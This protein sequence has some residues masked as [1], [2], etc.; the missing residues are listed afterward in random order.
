MV[1]EGLAA[2][3]RHASVFA[4]PTA[5]K[6]VAFQ[7]RPT[8]NGASVHTSGPSTAPPVWLRLL[9][10]GDRI[11]AYYRLSSTGGWTSIGSQT[12]AGLAG[13]VQVGLAVSSHVD[14][15]RA[16]ATFD[17]VTIAE[18]DPYSIADVG[19]VGMRGTWSLGENGLSIEGSGADIWGTADAFRYYYRLWS[20]NGTITVR[21]DGVEN[22]H[23]WAKAGVMFRETLAAGSK[24]V[25]AIV[26]PGKGV[27]VQYR[28]A[29]GGTS[30]NA[31]L[32]P[33]TAP[34]WLR[35]TRSGNTFTAFASED[36]SSWRTLGTTTVTM[37]AD[38][39]VGLPVT[40]HDN[41]MLATALFNG[42]PAVD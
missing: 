6:G 37:G 41:A 40:S 38:I 11:G 28:G 42:R 12:L 20:G 8:T 3:S 5:V 9:R 19:A 18:V 13:V 23:A 27:A 32:A 33:G 4:T 30:A 17:N 31:A 15:R 39:L 25:M 26:S 16:M 2:G 10:T 29:T 35:L 14:G 34:E 21:V 7:R 1:R 22:T 36:G 24:H